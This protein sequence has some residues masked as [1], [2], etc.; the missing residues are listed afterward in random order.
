MMRPFGCL[1]FADLLVGCGGSALLPPTVP[2]T[3]S[4]IPELAELVV[5]VSEAV[6]EAAA[7]RIVAVGRLGIPVLRMDPNEPA[8]GEYV[9]APAVMKIGDCGMPNIV[10][11]E[12]V[13][14]HE[15]G[16]AIGLSHSSESGSIMTPFYG[17][18]MTLETAAK[19]LSNEVAKAES[20]KRN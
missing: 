12:V 18:G 19:S 4:P 3:L 14:V 1:L 20:L 10:H 2:V 13:L 5:A 6:N 15:I 9:A 8:C 17:V 7:D 11:A 16:H